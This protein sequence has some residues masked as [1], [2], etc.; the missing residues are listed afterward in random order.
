MPGSWVFIP[1]YCRRSGGKWAAGT[2]VE[3]RDNPRQHL[4][5][6]GA[7]KRDEPRFIIRLWTQVHNDLVPLLQPLQPIKAPAQDL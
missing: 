3:V 4:E 2:L 6:P 5:H 1:L 7:V